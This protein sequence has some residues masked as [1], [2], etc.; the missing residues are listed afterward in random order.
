[1]RALVIASGNAGKI[2]EFQALLQHLPLD[3]RPQPQ[4]TDVEETGSSFASNARIKARAVAAATREWQA[5]Q[6]SELGHRE[7]SDGDS[8]GPKGRAGARAKGST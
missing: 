8:A 7:S 6:F 3:V 5:A 1:M 4:G 2:L